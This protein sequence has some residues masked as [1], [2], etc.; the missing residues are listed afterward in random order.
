M[1]F[2]WM[3]EDLGAAPWVEM[4]SAARIR[5]RQDDDA[6][7]K[8][9]SKILKMVKIMIGLLG[10][11]QLFRSFQVIGLFDFLCVILVALMG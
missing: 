2:S 8:F 11:F 5:S 9:S 1:V 6:W 3:R 4:Q 10:L 7:S